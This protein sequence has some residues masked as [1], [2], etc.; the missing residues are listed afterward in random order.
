[1]TLVRL[2]LWH[3]ICPP[4]DKDLTFPNSTLNFILFDYCFPWVQNLSLFYDCP[5]PTAPTA[6]NVFISNR[7]DGSLMY[8]Y[9]AKDLHQEGL[10]PQFEGWK[11][12]LGLGIGAVGVIFTLIIFCF[13]KIMLAT[14]KA[15]T[16]GREPIQS[17]HKLGR[18]GYCN[19]YKGK[20]KDG[21]LVA[22]KVLHPSTCKGNAEDFI[23]EVLVAAGYLMLTLFGL[24][25]LCPRKESVV[26]LLETRGTTG[27]IAPEVH[28][29]NFG[30]VSRK[31]DVYSYGM[32]V[33]EMVG[34]RNNSNVIVDNSRDI[35]YPHWDF[36]FCSKANPSQRPLMNK[37]LLMFGSSLERLKMPPKPFFYS[38]TSPLEPSLQCHDKQCIYL[39]ITM[40]MHFN[41]SPTSESSIVL[42][43]TQEEFLL[44]PKRVS[45]N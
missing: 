18:E 8:N 3:N 34:G 13:F 5:K 44:L 39:V 35:Y 19:V 4:P 29:R 27:Y 11:F 37:V 17:K 31:S 9:Y 22:V 41:I 15:M 14:Y 10:R 32:M 2:D 26:S 25:K 20:L 21:H 42:S 45:S 38:P 36:K 33:L 43:S 12:S 1:M 16:P 30:G 23:N 24:A 40:Y 7:S 28:S 6:A